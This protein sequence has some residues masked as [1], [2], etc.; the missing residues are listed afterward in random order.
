MAFEK[1]RR[2]NNIM[3]AVG[4][5]AAAAGLIV[6]FT[7][8]RTAGVLVLIIGVA[9]LVISFSISNA[10]YK[11]KMMEFFENRKKQNK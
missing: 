1:E 6:L 8:S 2:Y 5:I 10:L 9:L 4:L 3:M 11:I 7:V